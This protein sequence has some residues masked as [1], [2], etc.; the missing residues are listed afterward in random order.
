[1]EFQAERVQ[2]GANMEAVAMTRKVDSK[3]TT[4]LFKSLEALISQEYHFPY[5]GFD[6]ESETGARTSETTTGSARP[7]MSVQEPANHGR[8]FG[9]GI[10]APAVLQEGCPCSTGA[11]APTRSM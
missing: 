6:G 5:R 7:F 11:K 2:H 8:A 1:M 10:V 3:P 4:C 9:V